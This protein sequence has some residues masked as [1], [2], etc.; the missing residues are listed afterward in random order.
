M[1]QSFKIGTK[2]SGLAIIAAIS[3]FAVASPASAQSYSFP[4]HAYLHS[5][6]R[7]GSS[8]HA[9]T[10]SAGLFNAAPAANT[11]SAIDPNAVVSS[12]A[13]GSSR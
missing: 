1:K 13:R 11:P 3:S 5:G 9:L 12:A 7:V 10:R 2:K 8:G 4:T 6:A